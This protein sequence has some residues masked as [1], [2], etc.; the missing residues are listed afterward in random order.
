MDGSNWE[1]WLNMTNLALGLITLAAVLVVLGAIGYELVA[2]NARRVRAAAG[3]G[4]GLNA[5]MNAA[6]DVRFVPGLGLTMADGGERVE[7][8]ASPACNEQ[9]R[10]K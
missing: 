1:F 2:R 8:P 10:R 5:M 4:S 6:S 9:P 7:P 3:E